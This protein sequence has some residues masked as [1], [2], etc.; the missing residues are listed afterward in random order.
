MEAVHLLFLTLANPRVQV[1]WSTIILSLKLDLVIKQ[2]A[3]IISANPGEPLISTRDERIDRTT[4]R[5]AVGRKAERPKDE[6]EAL[7]ESC[8]SSR[9]GRADLWGCSGVV[10]APEHRIAELMVVSAQR[11]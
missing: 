7:R 6:V 9:N 1:S 4:N 11:L 2:G 5:A 8:I 3:A 10:C